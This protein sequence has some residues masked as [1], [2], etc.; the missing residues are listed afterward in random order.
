MTA[1]EA[2]KIDQQKFLAGARSICLTRDARRLRL[3]IRFSAVSDDFQILSGFLGRHRQKHGGSVHIARAT[4]LLLTR[5]CSTRIGTTRVRLDR[6]LLHKL[7]KAIHMLTTDAASD[8]LLAS[9]MA[10]HSLSNDVRPFLQNLQFILRDKA[11]ASTRVLRRPFKADEEIEH[12]LDRLVR[13][14][15]SPSQMI[16]FSL[17]LQGLYDDCCKESARGP[18][19]LRNMSAAKHRFDSYRKPLGR[20]C[21]DIPA[22]WTFCTRVAATCQPKQQE[23]ARQLLRWFRPHHAIWAAMAADASDEAGLVT[24]FLDSETADPTKL[25]CV[26][27]N[28]VSRI[29]ALFGPRQECLATVGFTKHVLDSISSTS[30]MVWQ[31]G[32]ER[33]K[34]KLVSFGRISDSDKDVAILRMRAWVKL[35]VAEIA[36]EFPNW[37]VSQA[38]AVFN[39]EY[40]TFEI[41][42]HNKEY[43]RRLAHCF[44]VCPDKLAM[45]IIR[46]RGRAAIEYATDRDNKS[47]WSRV[48]RHFQS[49]NRA[50]A[51]IYRIDVRDVNKVCLRYLSWALSTSGVEQGFTKS[52]RAFTIYQEASTEEY[53]EMLVRLHLECVRLNKA[54]DRCFLGTT[55]LRHGT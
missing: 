51:K 32:A 47:A 31:D 28:F 35:V 41:N 46:L 44:K 29:H 39:L 48:L 1:S 12:V 37:E 30:A 36:A 20:C 14:K 21:M 6:P 19:G 26:L 42:D 15:D 18:S 4:I 34:R 33:G 25:P 27:A 40:K 49:R 17:E 24:H 43:I 13:G 23:R 10:R 11:H 45:Q 53:E 38:F 55:A 54:D 3:D 8:E 2:I 7:R 9:E 16:Q 22:L 50:V 52:M 5:F